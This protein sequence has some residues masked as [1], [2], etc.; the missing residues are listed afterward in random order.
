[1]SKE[2]VVKTYKI[3]M[4]NKSHMITVWPKFLRE[5]GAKVG[6]RLVVTYVDDILIMMKLSDRRG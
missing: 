2:P 4:V 5:S 1:M 6:D 3:R